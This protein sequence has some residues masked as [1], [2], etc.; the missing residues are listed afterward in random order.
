M[1]FSNQTRRIILFV[2]I[3]SS[4][5][6]IGAVAAFLVLAITG[7]RS[8]D[9]QMI[10]AAYLAMEPITWY[11]IVPL[12]F[13]ALLSGTALAL[14]TRWGLFQHYWI[15]IKLLINILS[16]LLLLM[17]TRMIDEVAGAAAKGA[18]AA[19]D[20]HGSRIHLVTAAIVALAALLLAALLSVFKPRGMT[21]R[22]EGRK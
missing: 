11:I 4:I 13:A 10:R 14:G 5:G 8:A 15:I 17:H 9:T 7:L 1:P 21:R 22:V 16:I 3:V 2:H 12:S 18:L 19:T 20:L 6:W